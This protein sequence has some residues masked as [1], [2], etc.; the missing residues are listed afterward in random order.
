M[1]L[2]YEAV[3]LLAGFAAAAAVAAAAVADGAASAS[4]AAR[5]LAD[6]RSAGLAAGRLAAI[7]VQYGGNRTYV[8]IAAAPGSSAPAVLAGAWD[9]DG[10]PV[11]CEVAGPGGTG[12]AGLAVS[13]PRTLVCDP[14]GGEFAI[15]TR[16]GHA[17]RVAAPPAD[18][19]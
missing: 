6:A 2:S 11:R 4:D 15:S 8:T 13:V 3:V 9:A 5:S 18:A 10:L 1:M 14:H 12:I 19:P 16:S 17:L 7:D